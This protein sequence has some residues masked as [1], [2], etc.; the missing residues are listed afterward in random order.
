MLFA[1]KIPNL[2]KISL[3]NRRVEFPKH[4]NRKYIHYGQS[5][6]IA[7]EGVLQK[8]KN[9]KFKIKSLNLKYNS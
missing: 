5:D 7:D 1:Q 3:D 2:V 9:E 4:H 8:S 6:Q